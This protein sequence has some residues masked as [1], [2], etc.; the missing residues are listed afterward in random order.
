MSLANTWWPSLQACLIQGMSPAGM[1]MFSVA[2]LG[3][4][5]QGKGEPLPGF[6]T[7]GR[8]RVARPHLQH[9]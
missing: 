5:T 1:P 9:V 6:V 4:D 3:P 7:D 8:S 2:G